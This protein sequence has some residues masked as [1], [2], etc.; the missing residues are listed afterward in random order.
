M[1]EAVDAREGWVLLDNTHPQ[2]P[3]AWSIQI[4]LLH[5]QK[6]PIQGERAE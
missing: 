6:V 3:R 4:I 1:A 5:V 2:L